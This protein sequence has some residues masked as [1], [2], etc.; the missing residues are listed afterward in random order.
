MSRDS[1][2]I[3]YLLYVD[4]LLISCRVNKDNAHALRK[5][6]DLYCL[7]SRHAINTE[8]S[9]L[10]ILK[11]EASSL[12]HFDFIF[13]IS[14]N[15]KINLLGFTRKEIDLFFFLKRKRKRKLLDYFG[16]LETT[17]NVCKFLQYNTVDVSCF[18]FS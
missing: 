11:E 16:S 10:F 9:N 4:D 3:S 6:L 1:S 5:C 2:A 15:H 7:W 17:R 8:K 18:L 13:I 14:K 12:I